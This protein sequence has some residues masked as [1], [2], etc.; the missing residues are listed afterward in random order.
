M[1]VYLVKIDVTQAERAKLATLLHKF[2]LLYVVSLFVC[3]EFIFVNQLRLLYGNITIG[4]DGGSL[5]Q[6]ICRALCAS[7][8]RG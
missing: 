7:L 8:F 3:C 2:Q 4:N 6:S 1:V 5:E